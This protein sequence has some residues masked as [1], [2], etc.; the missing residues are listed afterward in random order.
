MS[1][2][3]HL[4]KSSSMY[5]DPLKCKKDKFCYACSVIN[6]EHEEPEHYQRSWECP[7]HCKTYRM[8]QNLNSSNLRKFNIDK[9]GKLVSNADLAFG[10]VIVI[11]GN[12]N[13]EDSLHFFVQEQILI[14]VNILFDLVFRS[15]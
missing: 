4:S 1:C 3:E 14:S 5:F 6:N 9:S 13:S 15:N 10:E 8:H 11:L 7:Q 2:N 12:L